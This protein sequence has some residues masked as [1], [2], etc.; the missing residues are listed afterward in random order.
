MNTIQTAGDPFRHGCCFFAPPS[1]REMN[2]N[3]VGQLPIDLGAAGVSI[4]PMLARVLNASGDACE[5]HRS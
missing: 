3:H 2:A 4:I 5:G 1:E